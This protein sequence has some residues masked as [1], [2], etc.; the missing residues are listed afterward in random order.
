MEANLSACLVPDRLGA[1]ARQ[2]YSVMGSLKAHF[3]LHSSATEG[4]IAVE[5][6]RKS[7]FAAYLAVRQAQIATSK[8]ALKLKKAEQEYTPVQPLYENILFV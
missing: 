1:S 5:R 6:F 7:I 4:K 8:Q 2:E 3:I